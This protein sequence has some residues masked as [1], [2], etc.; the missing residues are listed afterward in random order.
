MENRTGLATVPPLGLF[1]GFG[2]IVPVAATALLSA[3]VPASRGG[4]VERAGIV[5][6][7]SVLA[8]LGG[9]RRGLS[10]RQPGGPAP[11][12]M[13]GMLRLFA[14]AFAG[15]ASPWRKLSCLL[16]AAGFADVAIRD[17]ELAREGEAPSFFAPL[18]PPQMALAVGSLLLL[19]AMSSRRR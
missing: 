3:V 15:L 14:W 5:W 11:D 18:R 13:T 8:F 6:A 7:G 9:V 17:P 19:A 2:A 4:P 10:F 1:L 12:Q 16:L